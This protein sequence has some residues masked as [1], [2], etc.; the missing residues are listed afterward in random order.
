VILKVGLTGG[1]ASG[2]ST[3]ARMFSERGAF[4]V[5]S[6]QLVRSL[7][8][9]GQ[10]GYKAIVEHYGPSVLSPEGQIDRAALSKVALTTEE[11]ARRL[12]ALIHPLVI[13]EQQRL[14]EAKAQEPGDGVAIVEATL[15]LESGGKGRFDKIIV[16]DVPPELQLK[17]GMDRGMDREELALRMSR[18]LGREERLASA[19][20]LIHN[21]ASLDATASQV[22]R[23]FG[24]LQNDLAEL[25]KK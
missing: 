19:D 17:R 25:S 20:Y 5:D 16:V 3:V 1:I 13:A 4:V 22:D 2:K 9:K 8:E 21:G 11:R 10:A 7:Y 14:L 24:G 12:N 15:L 18:Q 6:D 23:I